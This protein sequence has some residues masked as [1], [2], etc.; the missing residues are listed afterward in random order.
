MSICFFF[1]FRIYISCSFNLLRISL[2][3]LHFSYLITLILS[4]LVTYLLSLIIY[5]LIITSNTTNLLFSLIMTLQSLHLYYPYQELAI[6]LL[7]KPLLNVIKCFSF[8][9]KNA[10]ANKDEKTSQ[11]LVSYSW[12]HFSLYNHVL[13]YNFSC[14]LSSLLM[15]SVPSYKYFLIAND[16]PN[17]SIFLFINS[18]CGFS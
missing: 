9:M 6:W 7:F 3:H 5:L 15:W 11:N 2:Y 16:F 1:F 18:F 4:F 10:L 17:Q 8:S 12:T 14:P 13:F